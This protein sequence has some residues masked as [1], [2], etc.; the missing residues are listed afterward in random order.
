MVSCV[1]IKSDYG[2]H[3]FSFPPSVVVNRNLKYL[4]DYK[5]KIPAMQK[6]GF[7]PLFAVLCRIARNCLMKALLQKG[8]KY[9]LNYDMELFHK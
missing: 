4:I 3:C 2:S 6:A 7:L 9:S 1:I 8:T 5:N